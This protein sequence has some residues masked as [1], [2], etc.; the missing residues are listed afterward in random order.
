MV[1][2]EIKEHDVSPV[3]LE[4]VTEEPHHQKMSPP[5]G[6]E[7]ATERLEE[8]EEQEEEE[9]GTKKDPNFRAVSGFFSGFAAAVQNT[10]CGAYW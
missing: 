1:D 2:A 5:A 10:V 8:E 3:D 9:G 4:P 7:G 6:E